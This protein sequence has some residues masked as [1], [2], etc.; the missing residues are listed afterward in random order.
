MVK[1]INKV[2]GTAMWVSEEC[3]EEYRAAGHRPAVPSVEPEKPAVR[4]AVKK[5]KK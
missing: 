3:A 1:F 4:P 5:S 2:T